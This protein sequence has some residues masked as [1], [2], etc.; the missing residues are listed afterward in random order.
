M[1]AAGL[2][3]LGTLGSRCRFRGY[4]YANQDSGRHP[5]DNWSGGVTGQFTGVDLDRLVTDHFPHKLSGAA[6]VDIKTAKFHHNRL[7]AATGTIVGGPGV[8]S[9]SLLQAAVKHMQFSSG[10]ELELLRDQVPYNRLALDLFMD[11]RGLRIDGRCSSPQSGIVMTNDRLCLLAAPAAQYQPATALIK[12]LV[13]ESTV[14][15]PATNQTDWLVTHLLMPQAVAPQ[16]REAALPS[17]TVRL[18]K[19]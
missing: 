9:R 18:R 16:T 8:I 10:V 17:A 12:T 19:E 1:L 11:S 5:I 7:E 3:E 4:I 15:V 14:Q 6:D 2:P 13:P